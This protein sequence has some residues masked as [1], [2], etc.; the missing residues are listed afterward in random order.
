MVVT[1]SL[2][3]PVTVIFR[4]ND[5]LLLRALDGLGAEQ[6]WHRPTEKNNPMLWIAGHI[7]QTRALI[8]SLTGHPFDTGWG[9]LFARG[10]SVGDAEKYPSIT[11]IKSV[12]GK[13]NTMLYVTFDAPDNGRL[14]QPFP[15]IKLPNAKT[16]VDQLAGFAMHDS[17]H[18][19]QLGYLRKA[20]GYPAIAG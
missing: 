16:G 5:D 15:G 11:E 8:L 10:S 13:I 6:L 19:G 9:D 2:I 18:V 20:L 7:A 4:I 3:A 17:Y 1:N 14:A 12:L